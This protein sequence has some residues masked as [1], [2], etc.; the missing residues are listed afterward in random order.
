MYICSNGGLAVELMDKLTIL[1]DAAKYDA[2]CT[3]SGTV[4]GGM[5]G[6]IG[7]ASNAGCCHTF[8]EGADDQPLLL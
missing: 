8:F 1:A 7:S 2:A 6:G 5:R 4:R 3:S